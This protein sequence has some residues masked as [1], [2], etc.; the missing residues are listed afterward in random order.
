MS[1]QHRPSQQIVEIIPLI[2]RFLHAEMRISAGSMGPSHFHLLGMLARQPCNMSEIAEKQSVS[3]PTI[4]NSVNLL[5]ERGWILRTPAIH[6]RRM[7][8]I[9][10]TP[11]GRQILDDSEQR[12]ENRV[13]QR[14][15]DLSPEDLEKLTVGLQILRQVLEPS[16]LNERS[17][18]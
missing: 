1:E 12:I 2:L 10:L 16:S 3:M 6:D 5:V 7:V 13:S 17:C 14:L 8:K 11:M 4:S 18:E 9:E 15:S